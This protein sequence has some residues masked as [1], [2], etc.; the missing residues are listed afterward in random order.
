VLLTAPPGPNTS[1]HKKINQQK[2]NLRSMKNSRMQH[3]I[4]S[5][6]KFKPEFSTRA[7]IAACVVVIFAIQIQASNEN[8]GNATQSKHT[9]PL[10]EALGKFWT[11]RA[12][13]GKIISENKEDLP[14]VAV[15]LKGKLVSARTDSNGNYML[16]AEES[17]TLVFSFIGYSAEE[18]PIGTQT[19]INV[20][21]EP[22]ITQLSEV[23]MMDYG[24]TKKSKRA[25]AASS[26]RAKDF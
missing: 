8:P 21:M 5:T 17:D 15:M 12:I 3:Q 24:T 10:P 13:S 14:G 23:V 4:N 19:V 25:G 9:D 1:G 22:D 2:Q 11:S 20:E 26:R 6:E 18:I 7:M 16:S